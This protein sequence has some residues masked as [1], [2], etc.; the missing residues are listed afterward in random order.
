MTLQE[1][2]Q[3]HES[4]AKHLSRDRWNDVKDVTISTTILICS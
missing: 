2:E 1:L 4:L 3:T